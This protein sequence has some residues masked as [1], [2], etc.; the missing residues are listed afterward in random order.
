MGEKLLAQRLIGLLHDTHAAESP[1]ARILVGWAVDHRAWLWPDIPMPGADGEGEG[2][3]LSWPRLGALAG[4]IVPDE[5]EPAICASVRT[6][7]RLL[8]LEGF[9]S[10]L[11]EAAVALARFP[12]LSPLRNRLAG[13]GE[14]IAALTARLAGAEA[15]EAIGRVRRSAALSLGL[16]QLSCDGGALDLTLDWAL[17]RL[18][19]RPF[20][21]DD[22]LIEALAGKRQAASL[23]RADFAEHEAAFDLLV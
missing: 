18:L 5:A 23:T 4:A 19:D 13:A 21:D 11:L 22:A 2:V 10:A 6:A 3:P 1:A 16:L 12:R 20:A 9:D 8:R 14:D 7:A 15:G 17:A